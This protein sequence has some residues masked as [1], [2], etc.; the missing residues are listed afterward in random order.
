MEEFLVDLNNEIYLQ[1][2]SNGETTQDTFFEIISELLIDDGVCK[3]AQIVNDWNNDKTG[4]QI[5][6][7]GGDPFND[8]NVLTIFLTT[9][10]ASNEI[11]GINM[12]ELTSLIKRGANYINK[13]RNNEFV[14]SLEK[15]SSMFLVSQLLSRRI[16]DVEKFRFIVI[17]NKLLKV[18]SEQIE[19]PIIN[20]KNS[21]AD[22]WDL[23]RIKDFMRGK[24]H[25]KT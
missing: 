23:D 5:D 24:I 14:S 3:E 12:A 18:R 20:D 19:T 2:A 11:I 22:I 10:S 15:T 7:Y 6:G 16:M 9:F 4:I 1:S 13:I 25:K 21:E 8:E 17:T